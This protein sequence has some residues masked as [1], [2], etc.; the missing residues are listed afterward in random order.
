MGYL[1]KH[2]QL[3]SGYTVEENPSLSPTILYYLKSLREEHGLVCLSLPQ[4]DVDRPNLMRVVRGTIIFGNHLVL[5]KSLLIYI[6]LI[7]WVIEKEK[8]SLF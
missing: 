3:T 7:R 6:K 4:Q 5:N 8:I 1:H 2:G